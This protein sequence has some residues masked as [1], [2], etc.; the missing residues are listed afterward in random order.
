VHRCLLL[1]DGSA[2]GSMLF[3]DGEIGVALT[4]HHPAAIIDALGVTIAFRL[5][6][7][8]LASP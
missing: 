2:G 1:V 8:C 3:Y 5:R 6:T 7:A 4:C